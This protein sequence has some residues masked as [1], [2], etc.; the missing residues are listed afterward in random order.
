MRRRQWRGECGL[1]KNLGRPKGFI[2]IVW[3]EFWVHF[4]IKN[5]TQN[6]AFVLIG[7]GREG[8]WNAWCKVCAALI[9][10]EFV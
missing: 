3:W 9:I 6:L 10:D 8:Q 1:I 4:V 7:N 5:Y 2:R